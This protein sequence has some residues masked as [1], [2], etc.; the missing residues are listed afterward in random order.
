L[1]LLDIGVPPI[2]AKVA[3][4]IEPVEAVV[5][6]VVAFEASQLVAASSVASDPPDIEVLTRRWLAS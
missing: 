5:G 3:M 4:A 2:V 1:A 6:L